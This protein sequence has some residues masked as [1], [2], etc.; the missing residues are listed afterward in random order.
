MSVR[1]SFFSLLLVLCGLGAMGCGGTPAAS[2]AA[3][4]GT[5]TGTSPSDTGTAPTDTGVPP[6]D[7]GPGPS[8]GG[9]PMTHMGDGTYYNGDGTG[10]CSFPARADMLFAAMNMPDFDHAS[11][12]GMCV[13]VTGP[14]GMVTVPITDLCPECLSGALDLSPTAFAMLSPLSAGRIPIS[15]HEV[16]CDVTG[17][18]VF[19]VYDGSNPYYLAI[20]VR[21]A[22]NRLASVERRH[23]DGSWSALMRQDYGVWIE[24]PS[25]APITTAHLR[26]TDVYG[27]TVEGDVMITPGVDAD[28]GG[29]FPRCS[30]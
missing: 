3:T 28:A 7:T 11:V 29:Q 25:D 5:D 6:T 12:C 23:A 27:A 17:P 22:R 26:A 30:P 21:N 1:A 10:A 8:C 16:P 4:P 2:D 9:A 15:W 19:H 20:H 13:E 18:V 24:S 14:M